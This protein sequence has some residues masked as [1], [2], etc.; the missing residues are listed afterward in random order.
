[1]GKQNA[2]KLKEE[3]QLSIK[4]GAELERRRGLRVFDSC[5]RARGGKGTWGEFRAFGWK[6]KG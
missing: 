6:G 3:K 1:M 4:Q 5:V 2:G